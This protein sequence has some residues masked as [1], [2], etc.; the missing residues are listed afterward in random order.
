MKL[1]SFAAAVALLAT[2]SG[3]QAAIINGFTGTDGDLFISI[4]RDN[5]S[6]A[7]MIIDT[8]I[9]LLGLQDGTVTSWTS[10]AAQSAAVLNFLG[11][12][13]LSDFRFNAGGVTNQGD[14]FDTTQNNDIGFFVTS[15][16]PTGSLQLLSDGMNTVRSNIGNFITQINNAYDPTEVVTNILDGQPGFHN[17]TQ[18]WS[19]NV[20]NSLTTLNTE[21]SV[22]NPLELFNMFNASDELF[23]YELGV[24]QV[25][26]LSINTSTGE[27]TLATAAPI[28]VPAA[29][30]LLGS[31][32]IGLMGVA[33]RRRI[34][35]AA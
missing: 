3:A 17:N 22:S 7:S 23:G 8:N 32:L 25:G 14:I 9:S 35:A 2:A 16:S 33:R 1:K 30:W 34:V 20:G 11:T 4:F 28:P 19:S 18:F 31:G 12:G 29:V 26:T 15:S 10:D 21:G 24:N 6:P 5:S 13:N 27:I